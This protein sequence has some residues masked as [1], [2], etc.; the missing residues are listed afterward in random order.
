MP[1]ARQNLRYML[2]R[3]LRVS[4]I[5]WRSVNRTRSAIASWGEGA[6]GLAIGMSFALLG[7]GSLPA[8]MHWAARRWVT[9]AKGFGRIAALSGSDI[10]GY[11]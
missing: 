10:V 6:L 7:L 11:R 4:M 1:A 3:S 2:G 5:Y 9:S 8:G